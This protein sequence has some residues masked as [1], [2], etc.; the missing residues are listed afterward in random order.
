MSAELSAEFAI[1]EPDEVLL[2][3]VRP[4]A[5]R[6]FTEVRP[7][8]GAD[9]RD[10]RRI[11]LDDMEPYLGL[12]DALVHNTVP[13]S[14]RESVRVDQ[15]F[16]GSCANGT[17]DDLAMAAAIVRGRRSC[18]GGGWRPASGSSSRPAP[19]RSTAPPSARA[20]WRP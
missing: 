18:G 7:D 4:R 20:M 10:V 8:A 6:P 15:C 17:L 12:P 2:E 5:A 16:V 11:R 1:W 3:H 13:F 9:Y 19:R 14:F